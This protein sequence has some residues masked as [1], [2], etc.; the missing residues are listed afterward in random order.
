MHLRKERGLTQ[1]Q[2]AEKV[3]ITRNLLANYEMGRTHLTDESIILIAK[4][5]N[6]STDQ[7]LG[8]REP[9]EV[10]QV[11]SV[12]LVRRMQK[13]AQLPQPEQKAILKTIDTFLKGANFTEPVSDNS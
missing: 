1:S 11:P 8:I 12:R 2:L 6:V 4:A 7:L 5:L 13:I 10:T 9:S 3:G